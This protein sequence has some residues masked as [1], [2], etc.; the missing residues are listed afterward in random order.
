MSV[1][2]TTHSPRVARST[3]RFDGSGADNFIDAGS[4]IDGRLTSAWNWCSKVEKK[5]YFHVFRLCG[6]VSFDGDFR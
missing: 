5:P 4:C 6:F 3:D 1:P 2:S